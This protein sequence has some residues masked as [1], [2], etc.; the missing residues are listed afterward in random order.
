MEGYNDEIQLKDILIKSSEYKVF[1]LKK[2]FAIV[3][4]SFLFASI[5]VVISTLVDTKYNADLTFIVEGEQSA[6]PL[7]N[8]SGI[9]NQFG[10]NFESG[11]N[12]TFSQSNIIELLK[13]RGVIIN[14]LMQRAKVNGKTDLLIEHY[15]EINEIK[16]KWDESDDFKGVSFHDNNLYIHDRKLL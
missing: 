8:M 5:G 15:L 7:G 14:T 4:F 9:A 1:L 2:K 11:E 12:S 10:F 6:N 16:N 13:S 3:V